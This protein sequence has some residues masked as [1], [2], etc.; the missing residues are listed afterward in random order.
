MGHFLRHGSHTRYLSMEKVQFITIHGRAKYTPDRRTGTYTLTSSTGKVLVFVQNVHVVPC[1]SSPTS[2][3][4]MP[5]VE[6][7]SEHCPLVI[8]DYNDLAAK[9]DLTAHSM[10]MR[11]YC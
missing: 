1:F 7:L 10:Y 5:E 11:Y 6:H 2:F 8:I 9:R 4:T 3:A